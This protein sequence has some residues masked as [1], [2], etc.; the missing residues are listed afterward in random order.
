MASFLMFLFL[1]CLAVS[2]ISALVA[3]MS[4]YRTSDKAW[5]VC[6]VSACLCLIPGGALLIAGS[7]IAGQGDAPRA[8]HAWGAKFRK[9]WTVG[10]CQPRDTDDNGYI[11]CTLIGPDEG[12]DPE[13]IECGVNR[14][15][16]GLNVEGCKPVFYSRGG[17]RK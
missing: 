13:P 15:Y 11:T 17:S 16:H 9:G 2:I 14:W 12:D 8:A 5:I 6:F 4:G 1:L 3:L 10:E 7:Y